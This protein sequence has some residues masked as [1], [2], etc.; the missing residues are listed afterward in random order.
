MIRGWRSLPLIAMRYAGDD[1]VEETDVVVAG[2]EA[3][4]IMPTLTRWPLTTYP[5]YFAAA[6]DG[7]GLSGAEVES[8]LS[9]MSRPVVLA[10]RVRSS[11]MVRGA[12]DGCDGVAANDAGGCCPGCRWR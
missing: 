7:K 9:L 6:G 12:I 10:L 5:A 3:A 2:F 1:V 4:T 8:M 11:P